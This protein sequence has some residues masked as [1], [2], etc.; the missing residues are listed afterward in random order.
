[1]TPDAAAGRLEHHLHGGEIHLL[2]AHPEAS[3]VVLVA[4]VEQGGERVLAAYKP[5]RGERPLWDFPDGSL[6]ARERACYLLS[7]AAGFDSVPVTVLRSGPLGP[8]SVQRWVGSVEG[9]PSPVD[10]SAP[11]EVPAG[12]LVVLAGEDELGRPVV[13]HHADTASLRSLAVLDAVLNSSDRK[14]SHVLLEDDRAVAIDNAVSLHTE[15]KLRTVLWGWA[16]QPLQDHDRERVIR[17]ERALAE[18]R[19]LTDELDELLTVPEVAALRDRVEALQR[20]GVHPLPGGDW[21]AIP[22][23]PV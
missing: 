3:N 17:L 13:V 20:D 2:G 19:A 14:G 23:P 1:M 21:P 9:G 16:G 18:D 15:P 11:E 6:A 10:V 22:W 7:R 5:V 8:G 12:H 4:E